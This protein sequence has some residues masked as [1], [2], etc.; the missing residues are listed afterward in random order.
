MAGK[1]ARAVVVCAVGAV[2]IDDGE[3]VSCPAEVGVQPGNPPLATP[4][5]AEI[6]VQVVFQFRVAPA[7]KDAL[8]VRKVQHEYRIALVLK[9]LHGHIP[10]EQ[11]GG[12][13]FWG[14]G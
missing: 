14:S 7:N 4:V 9:E 5:T 13:R 3:Q 2:Q 12:K 10:G 1:Q 8:F 6:N 11:Y